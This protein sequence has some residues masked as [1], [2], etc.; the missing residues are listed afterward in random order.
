MAKTVHVT[1]HPDGGWQVKVGGE[2][3]AR[4]RFA[5]QKEAEAYGRPLSRQL[6]AEFHIHGRDGR[7]RVKD[8][9]GNDPRNIPG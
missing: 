9:H 3:R 8:S 7:I 6:G 2:G 1:S 5:T 4:K